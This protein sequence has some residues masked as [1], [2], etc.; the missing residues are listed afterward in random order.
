MIW[1]LIQTALS[2]KLGGKPQAEWAVAIFLVL[3][4]FGMAGN[5]PY[6][7]MTALQYCQDDP[8][9]GVLLLQLSPEPE[10]PGSPENSA[11]AL[12]SRYLGEKMK[13]SLLI[14]VFIMP[15]FKITG[16]TLFLSLSG[17]H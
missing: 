1:L 3:P 10:V 7:T 14:S 9:S 2:S 8:F 5:V 11:Q 6:G 17:L 12:S 15:L 4:S 13:L 16:I